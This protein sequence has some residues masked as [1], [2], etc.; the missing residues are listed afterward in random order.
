M[1]DLLEILYNR[2]IH[3]EMETERDEDGKIT[4]LTLR[5]APSQLEEPEWKI[6]SMEDLEQFGRQT[7]EVHER[8]REVTYLD[9]Q[10]GAL[11]TRE[12]FME[13]A[14]GRLAARDPEKAAPGHSREKSTAAWTVTPSGW[15]T[16]WRA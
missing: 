15:S 12:E 11:R 13:L 9:P 2:A 10:E 5:M 4:G 6:Q 1:G 16:R 7:Q 3:A 14:A 8:G